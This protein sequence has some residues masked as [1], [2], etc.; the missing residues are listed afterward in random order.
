MMPDGAIL[1]PLLKVEGLVKHFEVGG[2]LFSG[3]PSIVRAF[4]GVIFELASNET[5]G[6]V[7]ECSCG[8]SALA[9]TLLGLQT[10][11]SGRVVFDGRDI[12][13]PEALASRTLNPRIPLWRKQSMFVLF[14]MTRFRRSSR[15][16]VCVRRQMFPR[17]ANTVEAEGFDHAHPSKTDISKR[18]RLPVHVWGGVAGLARFA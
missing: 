5:L 18:R 10:P 7:G 1:R 4:D 8:R 15:L 14:R 3:A 6:I 12:F 13:G 2:G 11:S 9:R 16:L 17:I